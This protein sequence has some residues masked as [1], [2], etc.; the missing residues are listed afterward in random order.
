MSYLIKYRIHFIVAIVCIF[1]SSFYVV[2]AQ[3][4]AQQ[5]AG[6]ILLQVEASGEAWY[7]NPQDNQRYYLGRPSDAFDLMRNL[8]LGISESNY[9]KFKDQGAA[10]FK[11]RILLRVESKGEAYYVNPLNAKL[12]YLGRPSDAFNVM[13]TLGLGISN[14]NL[15]Q[16]TIKSDLA[17]NDNE[18]I[19]QNQLITNTK[20]Y[21]WRYKN[22]D[23]SLEFNLSDNLYQKY[24]SAAKVYTYYPS[25][26][27][28]DI[29]EAFYAMFLQIDDEDSETLSLLEA[30]KNKADGLGFSPDERAAF[31]ISFIQY[32]NYD[33]N[34]AALSD[35]VPNY[36]FETLYLQKGICSDTS[37]LA[38]LWLRELGYGA[39][40]LDFPEAN[41]AA[42]G[43]ACPLTDSIQSSGYCFVET[44]NYFPIAVVPVINNN[45]QAQ[46]IDGN[47]NDIFSIA[48][49]GRVEIRQATKGRIYQGISTVKQEASF[50]NEQKN[51][52]NSSKIDLDLQKKDLDSLYED[53]NA[54][55]QLL[56][57]YKSSLDLQAYNEALRSYNNL[58]ASYQSEALLYQSAV[59]DY[60]QK[61]SI[62][63]SRYQAFYQQ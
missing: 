10:S 49:L 27:P 9:S 19:S 63:N 39:A 7:V 4:L 62:F 12:Y 38:V 57:T 24:H 37:F 32:L 41:H 36:P 23:Y 17:I 42:L 40:I 53:I 14:I 44:T 43:I 58:V 13:R 59:A 48:Q 30:L 15:A 6:R 2:K 18:V 5:L 3:T 11:G 21:H 28:D 26:K 33:Y 47:L 29:R 46:N 22:V 20:E 31:I 61:V 45:G 50:L 55:Q 16:I 54:Q 52:V 25:N 35:N 1:V 60:N 8:G 56:A 34:R 51:I